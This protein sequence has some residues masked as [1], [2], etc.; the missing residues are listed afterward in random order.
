MVTQGDRQNFQ[1]RPNTNDSTNL[2]RYDAEAELWFKAF[3]SAER[4]HRPRSIKEDL[5][6]I[7][8]ALSLILNLVWLAGILL[9]KFFNWISK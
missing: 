8:L 7:G 1:W 9:V 2:A 5:S 3:K 4:K 6:V